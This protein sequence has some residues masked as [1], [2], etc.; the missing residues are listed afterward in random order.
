MPTLSDD[1][2]HALRARRHDDRFE[3]SC[4]VRGTLAF[5]GREGEAVRRLAGGELIVVLASRHRSEAAKLC[6]RVSCVRKGRPIPP[7]HPR[8]IRC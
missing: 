3:Q 2:R 6:D 4:R 5:D 1:P 8:Q 7:P